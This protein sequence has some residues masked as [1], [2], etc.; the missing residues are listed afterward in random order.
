[1]LDFHSTF[2][3]SPPFA[4]FGHILLLDLFDTHPKLMLFHCWIARPMLSRTNFQHTHLAM[5]SSHSVV[6]A[7]NPAPNYYKKALRPPL[8]YSHHSSG[9]HTPLHYES[10]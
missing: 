2:F 10:S 6:N 4:R 1:M 5:V 9:F 7:L 3:I 8:T